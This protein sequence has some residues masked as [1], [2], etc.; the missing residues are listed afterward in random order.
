MIHDFIVINERNIMNKKLIIL[1][2]IYLISISIYAKEENITKQIKDFPCYRLLNNDK[3]LS[4]QFYKYMK[5]ISE[6]SPDGKF[7][8][9]LM[10]QKD[11]NIYTISMIFHEKVEFWQWLQLG[12]KFSDIL[13]IKYYQNNYG[14]VYPIAH[15]IAVIEELNLIK[16]YAQKMNFDNIPE[17]TLVLTSPIIEKYNVP[18][19]KVF[20][21]LKFNLGYEAQVPFITQKDIETAISI[22]EKSNYIY[23]DKNKILKEALAFVEKNKTSIMILK[24]KK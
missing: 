13:N 5:W 12:H 10:N 16:Y 15:R 7:V 17:V 14:K 3:E 1:I 9:N 19:D 6:L 21:R 8:F 22:Y 24:E 2:V 4:K 11:Q 20:R 23:K 18:L